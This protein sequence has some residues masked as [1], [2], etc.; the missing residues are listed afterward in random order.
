VQ[1]LWYQKTS[2]NNKGRY[3]GQQQLN[4]RLKDAGIGR[5]QSNIRAATEETED[6]AEI[7]SKENGTDKQASETEENTSETDANAS[8]KSAKQ[9][10]SDYKQH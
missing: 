5:Q 7:R 4:E 3:F 2:R 6:S 8:E 1:V 10:G 9:T